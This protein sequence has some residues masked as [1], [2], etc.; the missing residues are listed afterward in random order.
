MLYTRIVI[1]NCVCALNYLSVKWK[2]YPYTRAYVRALPK[3]LKASKQ[4]KHYII[5]LK[6]C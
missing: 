5:H 3:C 1:I 6:V 4:R 2:I